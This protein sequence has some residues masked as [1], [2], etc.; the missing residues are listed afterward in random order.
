MDDVEKIDIGD[1]V[2]PWPTYVSAHLNT[3]QKTENN[4]VVEGVHVLCC[5]GLYRDARVKQGAH[6]T[7]VTD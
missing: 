1:G 2:V 7:S 5:L 6:R 4:R 3:S